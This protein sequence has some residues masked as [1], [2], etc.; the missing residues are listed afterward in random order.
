MEQ[1]GPLLRSLMEQSAVA[2]MNANT[3]GPPGTDGG[4]PTLGSGA[5][6]QGNATVRLA[7]NREESWQGS[8]AQ[9]LYRRHTGAETVPPGNVVH[10]YWSNLVRLN[11][12]LLYPAKVGALGETLEQYGLAAA[13]LGNADGDMPGRQAVSIA[14]NARGTV[15]YGCVDTSLLRLN[16]DFPFGFSSDA[17]KYLQAVQHVWLDS[18]LIVIDW[19]DSSRIDAYREHLKQGRREQLLRT[20]LAEFDSLLQ[21]LLPYLDSDTLM[22]IIAPSPPLPAAAQRMTPLIFYD[23]SR[24]EGGGMLRSATTRREGIVTNIDVAPTVL[25]HLGLSSPFF[26]FGTPLEVV[27]LPAPGHLEA[28]PALSQRTARVYQQRPPIIRGFILSLIV[29]TLLV[30]LAVIARIRFLYLLRYPLCML[31]NFPLVLLLASAVPAFPAAGVYES[32]LLLLFIAFPVIIPALFLIRRHIVGCFT[33]SGLAACT[34]LLLDLWQG[35]PLNSR[36]LLGYDPIGGARFYGIGNEYMGVLIG[37]YILGSL[38]F[39]SL[40]RHRL[41]YLQSY[42]LQLSSALFA[43]AAFLIIFFMASPFYGANFGGAVTAALGLAMTLGGYL[44]L[45]GDKQISLL[46]HRLS[47]GK[48]GY[49]MFTLPVIFISVTALLIYLLNNP[50]GSDTVSHLGRTWELVRSN[51]LGELG[52]VAL[53]KLE[54]NMKLIRY[55]LWTRVL[56]GVFALLSVLYYYPVGL[57]RSIF[58]RE[59]FFKAVFGGTLVASAVAFLANDSG[60]VAAATVILYGGL[61]LFI[62]SLRQVFS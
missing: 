61:P 23:P 20:S 44:V 54:M 19:G 47:T 7:F 27:P 40:L 58:Q 46:W 38:S 50:A 15:A 41:S 24:S 26:L 37:S 39:F 30:G 31:L 16:E 18:S 25:R 59:P 60:V 43:A 36:S 2:L 52:N 29:A 57:M 48:K 21:G 51:G 56:L 8:S 10:P 13:V 62:L 45:S 32:V 55:S 5:R 28:L 33:F 11:E 12:A 34:L 14:M 49:K 4:Y 42:F 6:L 1:G 53:R 35:A 22:L 3:A 9:G 17:A